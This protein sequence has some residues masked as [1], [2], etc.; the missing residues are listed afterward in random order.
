MIVI[1]V[2]STKK[3]S[4]KVM[5]ISFDRR[6]ALSLNPGLAMSVTR[7][8]VLEY[9]HAQWVNDGKQNIHWTI[10]ICL[11]KYKNTSNLD[12]A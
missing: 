6:C 11:L 9:V 5:D 3:R 12:K 10:R 4:G 2:W 1:L 7:V 8:S